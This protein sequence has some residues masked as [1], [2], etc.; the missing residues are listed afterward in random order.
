MPCAG[1]CCSVCIPGLCHRRVLEGRLFACKSFAQKG[2]QDLLLINSERE[3]FPRSVPL[4]AAL[5]AFSLFV[6]MTASY[7]FSTLTMKALDSGIMVFASPMNGVRRFAL[8]PDRASPGYC[9]P[10]H[11]GMPI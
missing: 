6:A 8:S 7:T 2:L 10:K 5:F 9:H 1:P 4:P 3:G 11:Q